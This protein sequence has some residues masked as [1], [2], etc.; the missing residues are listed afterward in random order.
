MKYNSFL[1]ANKYITMS[2][3]KRYEDKSGQYYLHNSVKY[4][5]NKLNLLNKKSITKPSLTNYQNNNNKNII[6]V[7]RKKLYD[8]LVPLPKIKQKNKLKSEY[9]KKNLNNAMNNAKYIRRY[10]YSKNLEQKQ[11]Q[12]Y[13]EIQ[14][15]EKI[16]F[17]KIRL[18]QIWWK[19]IF[20]IIKI[21]KNIKGFLYRNNFHKI[22][23]KQ[24]KCVNKVINLIKAIKFIL[25]KKYFLKL[26]MLKPGIEYY[27]L[28][29]KDKTFKLHI[30]KKIVIDL[31]F[32]K[33]FNEF[34]FNKENYFQTLIS[35]SC[36]N[37]TKEN[38]QINSTNKSKNINNSLINLSTQAYTN[39]NSSL[40][41][42]PLKIKNNRLSLGL[43]ISCSKFFNTSNINN[44]ETN[45]TLNINRK[46]KDNTNKNMIN[47]SQKLR[48]GK[49]TQENN[50]PNKKKNKKKVNY[51]N[52]IKSTILH[53]DYKTKN[54]NKK[55]FK[56][57]NNMNIQ[58][59]PI[60]LKIKNK[61]KKNRVY[62][63]ELNLY[64]YKF[65]TIETNI[66]N[67]FINMNKDL[68]DYS[69]TNLDESQFNELLDNS[70]VKDYQN[71]HQCFSDSKKNEYRTKI[72][73][74][75]INK[76]KEEN[77]IKLKT[78]FE[79]WIR[80]YIYQKLLDLFYVKKIIK[81]GINII[82]TIYIKKL[83]Q[84]FLGKLEMIIDIKTKEELKEF[85]DY[86]NKKIFFKC[87]ISISNKYC[88][89]KYFNNYKNK[90]SIK[91]IIEK[92]KE[93]SKIN[94]KVNKNDKKIKSENL[95]CYYLDEQFLSNIP[96]NN[97]FI[98]NKFTLN[99]NLTNNCF[100][101]N[102]L[103]YNNNTNNIDIKL[104]CETYNENDNINANK[105]ETKRI[106]LPKKNKKPNKPYIG[107][108]KKNNSQNIKNNLINQNNNINII[109]QSQ[110]Y[111]EQTNKNN[112]EKNIINY[113]EMNTEPVKNGININNINK[114]FVLSKYSNQLNWDLITKKNQLIMVINIIERHRKL[115]SKKL[116]SEIFK[117]WKIN[118]N[119]DKINENIL[120]NKYMRKFARKNNIN[121][122]TNINKSNIYEKKISSKINNAKNKNIYINSGENN[123]SISKDNTTKNISSLQTRYNNKYYTYSTPDFPDNKKDSK[124]SSIY[125]KKAISGPVNFTKRYN[126]KNPTLLED[127]NLIYSEE[128]RMSLGYMSPENYYGFKKLNKIEEME[129]SFG[130]SNKK[131]NNTV[132]LNKIQKIKYD[133]IKYIK[134]FIVD[135]TKEIKYPIKLKKNNI[136]IE[137]IDENNELFADNKNLFLSLQSYFNIKKENKFNTIKQDLK[138]LYISGNE[139]NK[140]IGIKKYKSQNNI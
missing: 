94:R 44:L 64:N 41:S 33:Q 6:K 22:L 9:D 74:V 103:N 99:P 78:Y 13:N 54:K 62:E 32:K 66:G 107:L 45:K 5:R 120:S 27:F 56:N 137:D 130:S 126:N 50:I 79:K 14:Y 63:N 49:N 125:K 48:Y 67:N 121:I 69:V 86:A 65:Q 55:T 39:K 58:N 8:E 122:D 57:I 82:N 83:Y 97:D 109:S 88:L 104:S 26:K 40:T 36:K 35:R 135:D 16:Y 116:F 106:E 42:L 17:D 90:I 72:I 10:Q 2:G 96:I 77:N 3:T 53:S 101:I 119:Q 80:L 111:I 68:Q 128:N 110:L 28:K 38:L 129:I 34:D 98:Q 29:W 24:K 37:I 117:I 139:I 89:Y 140:K 75:E 25:K 73:K 61:A 15:K 114:S 138:D 11:I 47:M 136:I 23:E 102:N 131:K 7:H 123:N 1:K 132:S 71:I 30:L 133:N 60:N 134:P 51:R 127:N 4:Q 92:L 84:R 91:I 93:H 52:K 105:I 112:N 115:T 100:I 85:L 43:D 113:N 87:L 108:Y 21:Q 124:I 31:N 118:I 20:Q 12:L 76:E 18:V 70:T 81:D 46:T 59:H 19:T 95:N